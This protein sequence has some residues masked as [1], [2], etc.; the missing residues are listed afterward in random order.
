MI[1]EV[2]GAPDRVLYSPSLL[3]LGELPNLSCKKKEGHCN[4]CSVLP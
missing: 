4:L 1:L 2:I 3:N